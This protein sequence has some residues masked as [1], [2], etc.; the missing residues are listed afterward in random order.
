MVEDQR[1]AATRTDVLYYQTETL[2]NDITISGPVQADLYVSTS[3]TD[4]DW[5]VKIIDVFPDTYTR[6]RPKEAHTEMAGYQMLVRGEIFR[7]KFRNSYEK[8]EPFTPGKIERITIRLQDINHTFQKGHRIM[9]QIQS[10]WFPLFDRN[11]HK[12]M[13]IFEAEKKDFQKAEQH[14]YRSSSY[15]SCIVFR[16]VK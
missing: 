15:P 3:G 1:F 2:N 6:V 11:P 13:N 9:I 10:S 12:F 7:G 8:P 16:V 4:A 14:I 5:I